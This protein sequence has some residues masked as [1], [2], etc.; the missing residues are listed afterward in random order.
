MN[1]ELLT[2]MKWLKSTDAVTQDE[3]IVAHSRAEATDEKANLDADSLL[4]GALQDGEEA[5]NIAVSLTDITYCVKRATGGAKKGWHTEANKWVDTYFSV[6][7]DITRQTYI[8]CIKF[9]SS[10]VPEA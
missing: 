5:Y 10:N 2:V 4:A 7:S 6:C 1:K 3:L 9:G 8:N